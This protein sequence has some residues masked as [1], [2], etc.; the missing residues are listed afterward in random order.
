MNPARAPA[1]PPAIGVL[2]VEDH[3]ATREGLRAAIAS[4]PGLR[5]VGEA[6]TWHEALRLAQQRHI[7]NRNLNLE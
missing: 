7:S 5:V 4:Q 3:P 6:A 2:L 1:A